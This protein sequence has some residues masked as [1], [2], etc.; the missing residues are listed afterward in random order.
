MGQHPSMELRGPFVEFYEWD[1]WDCEQLCRDYKRHEFEPYMR[2]QDLSVLLKHKKGDEALRFATKMIAA[3]DYMGHQA[4]KGLIDA[5]SLIVSIIMFSNMPGN[6]LA[7]FFLDDA[8]ALI[9]VWACQ[10]NRPGIPCSRLFRNTKN[11]TRGALPTNWRRFQ[12]M[13][14]DD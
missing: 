2:A 13:H 1:D 3:F 11:R 12:D 14:C 10:E 7:S 4:K 5:V 9:R 6:R 8:Y